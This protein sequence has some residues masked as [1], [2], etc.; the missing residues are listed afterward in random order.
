M[1]S[2][3]KAISSCWNVLYVLLKPLTSYHLTFSKWIYP[4]AEVDWLCVAHLE[5]Q[6]LLALAT[7]GLARADAEPQ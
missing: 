3:L 5:A 6:G 2:F 7:R 1:R 4:L